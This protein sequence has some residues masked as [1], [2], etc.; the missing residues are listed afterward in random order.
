[1]SPHPLH[2]SILTVT[3]LTVALF[4]RVCAGQENALSWE[5]D[6]KEGG[7][8]ELRTA[9]P[10]SEMLPIVLDLVERARVEQASRR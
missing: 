4:V 9:H 10:S 7:E 6:L 5:K 3:L 1:M 8:E 2:R